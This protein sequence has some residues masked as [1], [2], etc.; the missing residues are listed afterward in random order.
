MAAVTVANLRL[1][2][3]P[4]LAALSDEAL[5]LAIADAVL[6]AASHGWDPTDSQYERATRYLALVNLGPL[7]QVAVSEGVGDVSRSYDT[8][9]QDG[10]QQKYD[11]LWAQRFGLGKRYSTS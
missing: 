5:G 3:A 8:T 2:P 6:D 1:S 9:K 4:G 10:W 7:I 11:R